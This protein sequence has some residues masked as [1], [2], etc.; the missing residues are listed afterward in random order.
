MKTKIMT[1]SIFFIK[2]NYFQHFNSKKKQ[3]KKLFVVLVIIHNVFETPR[4][5]NFDEV[6][7]LGTVIVRDRDVQSS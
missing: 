1:F 4:L 7:P 2:Q 3:L 5:Q 6:Y